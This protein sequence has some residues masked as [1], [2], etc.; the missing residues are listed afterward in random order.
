[1]VHRDT[2]VPAAPNPP[3][4]WGEPPRGV[5]VYPGLACEVHSGLLAFL[6]DGAFFASVVSAL[7]ARV[8]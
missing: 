7:P 2:T 3:A 1:L 5:V 8:L 4:G 6:A